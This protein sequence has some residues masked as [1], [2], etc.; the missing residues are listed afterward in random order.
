MKVWIPGLNWHRFFMILLLHVFL[1]CIC[2]DRKDISNTWDSVSSAIQTPQILSKILC[3]P[4]YFEL[5]S[6]CLDIPMKHCLFSLML[7]TSPYQPLH[8]MDIH[9]VLVKQEL[10]IIESDLSTTEECR[11]GSV[12]LFATELWWSFGFEIMMLPWATFLVS[13]GNNIVA[14]N[15]VLLRC[16]WW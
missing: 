6:R 15:F 5:C 3:C 4:S 2:F 7:L 8:N 12:L 14:Y 1:Y 10:D 16:Q 11:M 13:N 9:V